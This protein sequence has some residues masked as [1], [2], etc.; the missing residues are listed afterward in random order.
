MLGMMALVEADV[1]GMC[2]FVLPL[3]PHHHAWRVVRLWRHVRGGRYA[4]GILLW[5]FAKMQHHVLVL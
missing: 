5:C 2:R 3:G 4:V 1:L